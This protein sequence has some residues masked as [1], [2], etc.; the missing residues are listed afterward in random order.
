MGVDSV[1]LKGYLQR[2]NGSGWV[3][4]TSWSD[5]DDGRYCTMSHS[6]YV[7]SGYQYRYRVYATAYDGG[8]SETVVVTCYDTY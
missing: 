6:Y 2:Y 1:R 4:L 3:T 7:S 5:S 8:S